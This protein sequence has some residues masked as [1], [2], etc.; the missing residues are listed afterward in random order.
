MKQFYETYH[1]L[2]KLSPLVRELSWT[3]NLIIFSRCKTDEEREFYLRLCKKEKYNKRELERQINASYYERTVMSTPQNRKIAPSA[4]GL[5]GGLE[6][7]FKEQYVLEFLNLPYWHTEKELQ[8][9]LVNQM[10]GFLL[11]LGKDF[12]FV[13]QADRHLLVQQ[14]PDTRLVAA[15]WRRR[16]RP[17]CEPERVRDFWGTQS[18]QRSP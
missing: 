8:K 18:G 6:N 12:L 5:S 2:P 3:H 11:E 14:Q 1:Q 16:D 13:G 17:K 10:K 15:S 4:G 9:G 7:I